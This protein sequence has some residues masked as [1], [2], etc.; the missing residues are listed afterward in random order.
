M[1]WHCCSTAV[2]VLHGRVVVVLDE[3]DQLLAAQVVGTAY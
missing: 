3:V 2:E 1:Q